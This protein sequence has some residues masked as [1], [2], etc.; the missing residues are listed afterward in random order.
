MNPHF[1]IIG[2][3]KSGTTSL[4]NYLIQHPQI[5]PAKTKE[6]HFFDLN[7]HQE[8]D[9]YKA[10]FPQQAGQNT[11]TGESSPYYLFHPRVPQRVHQHFPQI[12]LIILLREPVARTWSHYHHEIRLKYETLSFEQAI[13]SEPQRLQ[14]E[15]EKL[16][17]ED[18]YY[19]FNH[20]HYSYLA[21]GIYHQQIKN[22]QQYFPKEQILI[23][24]S[25]DFY[26]NPAQTLN[27]TLEFLEIPPHT[28]ESYPKY[29]SG[30]YPEIYPATKQYLINYFQPHNQKLAK[31]LGITFW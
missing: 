30:S 3:Q 26:A 25:E 2:A 1:L 27:Q 12:K 28:I 16:L 20:Q 17:A 5:S 14:G 7:Y 13:A 10:Q 6:I 24:K 29:N 31:D 8:I 9:W 15:T 21:R 19:S 23:L 4:Y 11:I 22:W 18:N